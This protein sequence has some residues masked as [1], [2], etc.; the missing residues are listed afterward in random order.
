MLELFVLKDWVD[1]IIDFSVVKKEVNSYSKELLKRSYGYWSEGEDKLAEELAKDF[2]RLNPALNWAYLFNAIVKTTKKKYS[3]SCEILETVRE[4]EFSEDEKVIFNFIY[5]CNFYF[6]KNN[7]KAL[8]FC[9]D[10]I[11]NFGWF[12]PSY[13]IRAMLLQQS[14]SYGL[15]IADYKKA[16]G[17]RIQVDAIDA[18]I[19]Y[20]H[21]R[22]GQTLQAFLIFRKVVDLF[23]MN[24][25]VQYNTA[26]CH[27]RLSRYQS[28][29]EYLNRTERINPNFYGVFRTRGYIYLKWKD[30]H[31]ARMDWAKA[32]DLGDEEVREVFL[33]IKNL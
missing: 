15:A 11:E 5:S 13:L 20:C 4:H 2:V 10:N 17:E 23:P 14:E 33:E 18:N 16:K 19:A 3:Q 22:K 30:L 28:A 29:L 26:L 12:R 9:N 24:Y 27:F 32:L 7:E 1:K 21:L 25:E 6:Q 8:E 31:N